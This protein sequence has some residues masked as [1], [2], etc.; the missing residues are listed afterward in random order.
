MKCQYCGSKDGCT[1]THGVLGKVDELDIN[2]WGAVYNFIKY[3][4]LPFI[5]GLVLLAKE[6]KL[7]RIAQ[8]G[9]K[10]RNII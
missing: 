9:E 10:E 5:H 1:P 3:V 8:T 2:D 7:S 6:R 4:E